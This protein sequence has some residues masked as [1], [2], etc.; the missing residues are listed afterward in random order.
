VRL[1]VSILCVALSFCLAAADQRTKWSDTT[2]ADVYEQARDAEKAGHMAEAYM[3]YSQA[4]AMEPQNKLYWQRG[5]AVRTRAAQE[6]KVMPTVDLAAAKE[7]LDDDS[8]DAPPSW[9]EVTAQDRKDAAR[10]MP[11][12]ELLAVPD[13][14]DFDLRGDSRKLFEDVAHAYGLDCVFD[15]DYQPVQP[16]RFQLTGADY[17]D[18]LHAL[19]AATSSFIV[20]LTGKLFLVAKDTPQKRTEVEPFVAVSIQVPEALTAQDFNAMVTAVQQTFA[21]E[22][23]AFDTSNNTVILKGAISKIVPARA[24][25]EDLMYPKA[26]VAIEMK[27]L[28]VSRNDMLT[29]GVDLG[30][31]FTLQPINPTMLLSR[32]PLPLVFGNMFALNIISAALVAKMTNS[33]GNVLLEASTRSITGAPATLHVGD[34]YPILTAG[35]YGPQSFSQPGVGAA[36][37]LYTP[38]PSFNFEDLGLTLKITPNVHDLDSVTL[39]MDA[40][41]KVLTGQSVNNIPVVASRSLKT[42]S[43]LAFGEWAAIAG[44]LDTSEARSISGFAGISRI[45]YVGALLSLREKDKTRNQVLVLVRPQLLTAPPGTMKT[46]TFYVGSDTRPLTPI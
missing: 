46:H 40:Q 10:P 1:R 3:L 35:Y 16:F 37:Q 8:D 4:S 34:R 27:F 36:N 7:A 11:P 30:T 20:P 45:P 29:Y 25:F 5:Q 19:E 38:P 42:T 23:V 31:V 41:F 33:S 2:A 24:M 18:A 39:D 14:K 9:A 13:T 32:G 43:R 44:L 28:E 15:G 22:K 6:A 26:Q 17:R 12:T 21:V